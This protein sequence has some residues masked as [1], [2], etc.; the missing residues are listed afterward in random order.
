MERGCYR[1]KHLKVWKCILD[2][3]VKGLEN[4]EDQDFKSHIHRYEC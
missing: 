4:L 3:S 2:S 1:N